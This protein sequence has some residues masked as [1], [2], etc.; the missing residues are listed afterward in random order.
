[1]YI[2]L[3]ISLEYVPLSVCKLICF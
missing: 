2:Y 3:Y 1:M